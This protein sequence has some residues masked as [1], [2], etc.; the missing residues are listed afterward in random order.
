MAQKQLQPAPIPTQKN[1]AKKPDSSQKTELK[2]ISYRRG[3]HPEQKHK[4]QPE[5]TALLV[6]TFFLIFNLGCFPLIDLSPE[7]LLPTLG[8]APNTL[9]VNL[10]F[11]LFVITEIILMICRLDC[12]PVVRHAWRQ[13]AFIFAFY[14]FFWFSGAMA[15]NFILL[16]AS[17]FGLLLSEYIRLLRLTVK[18]V[19]AEPQTEPEY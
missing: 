4:T 10:A 19:G 2:L 17:G 16:L 1:N 5:T 18:S 8:A 13:L 6:L 7:R 3:T 14:G 11:A 12:N 9:Y 15:E